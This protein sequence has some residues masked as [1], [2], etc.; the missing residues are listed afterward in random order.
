MLTFTV[1]AWAAALVVAAGLWA[2]ITGGLRA[3]HRRHHPDC[4]VCGG[5]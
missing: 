5:R 1:A 2:A 4:P 3:Y